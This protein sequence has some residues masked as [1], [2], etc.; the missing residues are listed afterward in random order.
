VNSGDRWHDYHRFR[1][2]PYRHASRKLGLVFERP[3][4]LPSS[5]YNLC[6]RTLLTGDQNVVSGWNLFQNHS[7]GHRRVTLHSDPDY[8]RILTVPVRS[9]VGVDG[10]QIGVDSIGDLILHAIPKKL[11]HCWGMTQPA[12]A[13]REFVVLA[14]IPMIEKSS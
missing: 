3:N 6:D 14:S 8:I 4:L 9:V 11:L 2:L 7:R 12:P 10:I 1:S 5:N 13:S